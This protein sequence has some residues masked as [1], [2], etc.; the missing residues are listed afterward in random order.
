[1]CCRAFGWNQFSTRHQNV[2]ISKE[3]VWYP[4]YNQPQTNLMFRIH[5]DLVGM[6]IK[7]TFYW[8]HL[9][10]K[11]LTKLWPCAT[12]RMDDDGHA[13]DGKRLQAF[14]ILIVDTCAGFT[15]DTFA[16]SFNL[17][18]C[19]FDSILCHHRRSSLSLP[20]NWYII[21]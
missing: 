10:I 4:A 12:T 5:F 21:N 19:R 13:N 20:Q 11:R 17:S 16:F 9:V 18:L 3:N 7:T 15:I 8:F 2:S 14:S 1:M 6:M